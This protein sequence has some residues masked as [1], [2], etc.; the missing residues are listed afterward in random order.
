MK[1][2]AD[3]RESNGKVKCRYCDR[4][5]F[6]PFKCPYCSQYFCIEH[7]LPENHAC[8]EYWR[9]RPPRP[10]VPTTVV[11][12]K[13][14]EVPYEYPIPFRHRLKAKPF[15]FSPV[16]LK[17]LT[18]AALLVMGVGLSVTFQMSGLRQVEPR[19]LAIL[20]A[21]FTSVFLLHEVAHKLA[22][23]HY[24]LWAEFRLTMFGALLTLLSIVSPFFK[25]ISPGAVMIAGPMRRETAGKTALAGPLTNVAL[26]I[27]FFVFASYLPNMPFRNVAM[28]GAAFNAWIA[29][30]NLIPLGILDGSKVFGWN[31]AI[32][33]LAFFAS[34]TLTILTFNKLGLF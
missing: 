23:Q 5:V 27:I 11:E 13:P 8:S 20:A 31:K 14:E 1:C 33:G 22:A 2:L 6:L 15:W 24:G 30:F 28:L 19:I 29:V 25:I 4:D 32:W 16:E 21:V 18:L 26:S 7:R 34:I 3:F 9:A 10:E 12:R 17:H